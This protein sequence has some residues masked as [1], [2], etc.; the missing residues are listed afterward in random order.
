MIF[1]EVR[2]N[3]FYENVSTSYSHNL[4]FSNVIS[5]ISLNRGKENIPIIEV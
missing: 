3:T 1:Q 5:D 4:H 2:L